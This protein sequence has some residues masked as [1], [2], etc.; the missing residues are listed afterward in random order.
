[1]EETAAKTGYWPQVSNSL[2]SFYWDYSGR[3]SLRF[4][5]GDLQRYKGHFLIQG[6]PLVNSGPK[7][8]RV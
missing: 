4:E 1:M 8:K 3:I 7:K 2:L 6:F 5:D